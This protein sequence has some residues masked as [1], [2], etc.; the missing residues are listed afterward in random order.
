MARSVETTHVSGPRLLLGRDGSRYG[1]TVFMGWRGWKGRRL[2]CASVGSLVVAAGGGTRKKKVGGEGVG[3]T[4]VE[5]ER[6]PTQN[7]ARNDRRQQYEH[8]TSVS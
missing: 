5:R 2:V 7:R 3:L 6:V 4:F 8:L 1:S